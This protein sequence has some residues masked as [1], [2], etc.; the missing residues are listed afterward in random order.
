[1]GFVQPLPDNRI[2][3]V[4]ARTRDGHN[5]EVWTKDGDRVAAERIG[6]AVEHVLT[7]RSGAI[8]VGYF[9]EAMGA[10]GPEG[11]GLARFSPSLSTDWLYPRTASLPQI[12]G[13]YALNVT[14]EATYCCPYINFHVIGVRASVV[15]DYGPA[16]V[17]F[18]TRLLVDAHR[19]VLIG[20]DAA[21]PDLI[22][23]FRMVDGIVEPTGPLG[24]LVMPDGA[25]IPRSRSSAER[26]ICRGTDLHILHRAN[27]YR[28]GLGDLFP[29]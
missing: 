23:G 9:D 28:V 3:L 18:A 14:D 11:H 7:T 17:R 1:V 27:W 29:A 5:A 12:F 19:G 8:W 15:S 22:S 4:Q 2:L 20:G 21:Q 26:T 16:P 6:D 10:G 25:D 24:R 13:S